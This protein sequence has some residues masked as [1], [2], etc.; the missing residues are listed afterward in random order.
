MT[1][2]AGYTAQAF[3]VKEKNQTI[4]IFGCVQG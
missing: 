1:C 2:P 3:T 4:N